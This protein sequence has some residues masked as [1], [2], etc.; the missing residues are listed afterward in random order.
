MKPVKAQ[1]IVDPQKNQ[2]AS[3]QTDSQA[4][5][6]DEAIEFVF[7]DKPCCDQQ[8]ILEHRDLRLIIIQVSCQKKPEWIFQVWI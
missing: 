2:Q 6:I 5:D 4:E 8:V 1:L 7:F 3:G